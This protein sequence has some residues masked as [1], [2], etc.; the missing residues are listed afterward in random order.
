[1]RPESDISR[2]EVAVIFWRLTRAMDKNSAVPNRF[3]DVEGNEWFAQAVNYLADTG[4]LTGYEDGTFHPE[5]SISRS[6]FTAIISRFD[7]LDSTTLNPF[8]DIHDEHWAH[9]YVTSAYLKGWIAGYPD[10]TFRPEI[11]ITRA[12]TI[13]IVNYMLGRGIQAENVPEQLRN[14]YPD[15]PYGHWAFAEIIE[16]S[17]ERNYERLDNGYEIYISH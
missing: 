9:S 15:L 11:S 17:V 4:I 2:A 6:E 1:M 7:A 16:A 8:S 14:L 13:K 5:R 3:S 12:E 10:R